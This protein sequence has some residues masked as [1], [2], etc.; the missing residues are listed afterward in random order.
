MNHLIDKPIKRRKKSRQRQKPS[1]INSNGEFH[2]ELFPATKRSQSETISV[3]SLEQKKPEVDV[4][5]KRSRIKQL[6]LKLLEVGAGEADKRF[7]AAL[8]EHQRGCGF[9]VKSSGEL[10]KECNE[11]HNLYSTEKPVPIKTNAEEDPI[12][13]LLIGTPRDEED[14]ELFK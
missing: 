11:L 4:S 9:K 1:F 7:E 8:L 5:K 2:C 13:G 14:F 6:T 10:I 3:E 12:F